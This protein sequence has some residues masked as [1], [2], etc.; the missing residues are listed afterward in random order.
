ME[1]ITQKQKVYILQLNEKYN[2]KYNIKEDIPKSKKDATLYIT[3]IK[4]KY[5]IIDSHSL[6]NF[7]L[8]KDINRLI[9]EKYPTHQISY[10]IH[11][12]QKI[13]IYCFAFYQLMVIDWDYKSFD[14]IQE[15]VK[16]FLINNPY[17][18]FH[19][20]QTFNG[21]H[22]YCLSHV[23]PHN[24][25]KSLKYMKELQCDKYYMNFSFYTGYNIRLNKKKNR[26]EE[27]IEK[28][29]CDIGDKTYLNKK[30]LKL[31]KIK[32]KYILN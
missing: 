1:D 4:D 22:A 26:N 27:F 12:I 17:F 8:H 14:D 2:E 21:Y 13:N 7:K 23:L 32:D 5:N 9:I 6:K 30:L 31:L 28:F 25:F 10:D 16:S 3:K 24:N 11:H 15:I 18:Y 19:I 20:Y 29:I